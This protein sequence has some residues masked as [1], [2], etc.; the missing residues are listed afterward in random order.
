MNLLSFDDQDHQRWVITL[1]HTG[2]FEAIYSL[3]NPPRM[4]QSIENGAAL[5]ELRAW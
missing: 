5:Q 2:K 3:V 4:G 1:D